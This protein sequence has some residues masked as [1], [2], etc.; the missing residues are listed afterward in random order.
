M[1]ILNREP[2]GFRPGQNERRWA[3]HTAYFGPEPGAAP[4]AGGETRQGP[5]R[6]AIHL[7]SAGVRV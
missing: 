5:H 4:V 1:W 3:P 6:A 2:Q 7:E